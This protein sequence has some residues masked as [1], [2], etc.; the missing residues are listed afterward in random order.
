MDR[1][2]YA[3]FHSRD[4]HL[5]GKHA[6]FDQ[7]KPFHEVFEFFKNHLKD[8]ASCTFFIYYL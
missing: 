8:I 2:F 1:L 6:T 5:I 4:Y 7:I 3:N